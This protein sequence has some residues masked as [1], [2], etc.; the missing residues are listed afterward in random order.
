MPTAQQQ[1]PPPLHIQR[2]N[3]EHVSFTK[4][5]LLRGD[6][7]NNIL[8]PSTKA[9]VATIDTFLEVQSAEY[10]QDKENT[11][12]IEDFNPS[13][14]L[15][16]L[17]YI[18]HKE[19]FAKR[20]DSVSTNASTSRPSSIHSSLADIRS[21]KDENEEKDTAGAL[22]IC[23]HTVSLFWGEFYLS[24]VNSLPSLIILIPSII[25]L[26]QP[27]LIQILFLQRYQPDYNE[28]MKGSLMDQLQKFNEKNLKI[29]NMALEIFTVCIVCYIIKFILEWPWDWFLKINRSLINLRNFKDSLDLYEKDSFIKDNIRSNFNKVKFQYYFS[30]GLCVIA[31]F[32]SGGILVLTRSFFDLESSKGEHNREVIFTDLNIV[33]F[34]ICGLIRVIM[35][36]SDNVQESTALIEQEALSFYTHLR[37][38]AEEA[39]R[40]DQEDLMNRSMRQDEILKFLSAKVDTH[41]SFLNSVKED[42]SK[43]DN[44]L[45]VQESE[46]HETHRKLIKQDKEITNLRELCK[47]LQ[48]QLNEHQQDC[49]QLRDMSPKN[50]SPFLNRPSSPSKSPNIRSKESIS[51]PTKSSLKNGKSLHGIPLS[52]S[53]YLKKDKSLIPIPSK[54]LDPGNSNNSCNNAILDALTK[55]KA[56]LPIPS[57][58]TPNTNNAKN[59]ETLINE[60]TTL[61]SYITSRPIF[62][63]L[64]R[65][66]LFW[67]SL[68]WTVLSFIP[69]NLYNAGLWV[70]I[71]IIDILLKGKGYKRNTNSR[72]VITPTGSTR[73]VS[74]KMKADSGNLGDARC[75]NSDCLIGG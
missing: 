71:E 27:N 22:L 58:L 23:L 43:L 2:T 14:N 33:L 26:V 63:Y 38:A 8:K 37:K 21:R 35:K 47:T 28:L 50:T 34:I 19:R 69:L 41:N 4:D 66:P 74:F 46:T 44:I 39:A 40:A 16:K 49:F 55:M 25:K 10:Y 42:R 65:I 59:K 68:M 51:S 17:P 9:N 64:T 75:S 72:V 45:K 30:L 67:V 5:Q 57:I 6:R 32:I 70:I 13:S 12:H 52:Q 11:F 20:S 56:F 61:N 73:S 48:R 3:G 7:S 24:I 29:G 53:P 31:P 36:L 60:I 18:Q 1:Q 62:Q 54:L 15:P